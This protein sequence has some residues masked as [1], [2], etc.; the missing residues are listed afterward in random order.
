MYR[1]AGAT[2]V[3][4]TVPHSCVAPHRKRM[5]PSGKGTAQFLVP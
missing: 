5:L 4:D 3:G 2:P 1:L